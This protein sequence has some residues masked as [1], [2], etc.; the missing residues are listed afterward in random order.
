M[1][2]PVL[3]PEVAAYYDAKDEGR[4]LLDSADGRLESLRTR[5]I[6]TRQLPSHPCEVLDV[7][8][9]TGIHSAWLTGEGHRCTVL[10]PMPRHVEAARA[11]GL[12][13]VEGDA[14]ALPFADDSFDVV[15]VMGPM[16]HLPDAADRRKAL[17]EAARVARPGA[18]IAAAAIGRFASLF[19]NAGL[20]MLATPRVRES[21]AGILATG[22]LI[23]PP[24]GRFTTAFFHAPERLAAELAAVGAGD[25]RVFGVEGPAWG[26]LRAAEARGVQIGNEHDDP[27]FASVLEA[28]RLADDHP[29]LLAAAG[30]LLAVGRMPL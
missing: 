15:L 5:E 18:L 22:A 28:A 17:A 2:E 30:H 19:E 7:G 27:L 25:V 13:S 11:A 3:A 8:G 21:V 12:H 10:D 20:G 9:G 6:L 4:R 24:P 16:Y 26:M 29:E 23:K 14:R 1:N